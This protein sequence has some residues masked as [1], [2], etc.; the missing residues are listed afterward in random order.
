[1]AGA[2]NW[3]ATADCI[4][5]ENTGLTSSEMSRKGSFATVRF[6]QF[7]HV[8]VLWNTPLKIEWTIQQSS[9]PWS[10][11]SPVKDWCNPFKTPIKNSC[12]SKEH[13][14]KWSNLNIQWSGMHTL[15]GV[16]NKFFAW[17]PHGPQEVTGNDRH[18]F[19]RIKLHIKSVNEYFQQIQIT[20]SGVRTL[21]NN[22][23]IWHDRHLLLSATEHV[24]RLC[25]SER[26]KARN[27]GLWTMD[28]S[29]TFM[30]HVFPTFRSPRNPKCPNDTDFCLIKYTSDWDGFHV[31]YWGRFLRF[32]KEIVSLFRR[33]DIKL[34]IRIFSRFTISSNSESYT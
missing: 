32:D 16:S 9:V 13:Y 26:K 17:H 15:L 11:L 29:I 2:S 28:C 27:S 18:R 14:E 10:F 21:E 24:R 30:K 23:S 4:I 31:L 12:A 34:F 5:G 8:T 6:P 33:D 1:M 20:I 7:R 25:L 19:T 3:W 22:L